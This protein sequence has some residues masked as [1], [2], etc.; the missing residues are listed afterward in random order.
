MA[1][2]ADEAGSQLPSE[3]PLLL[4]T[5]TIAIDLDGTL[6]SWTAFFIPLL[7]AIKKGDPKGEIVRV[8]CLTGCPQDS[9]DASDIAEKQTYL[10]EL[11]YD[12]LIDELHVVAKPVDENKADWC[13]ANN[14]RAL[15]D[16]NKKN[17][18]ALGS[19][20]LGLLAWQSRE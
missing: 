17:V 2:V 14:A 6:D 19:Q 9:V 20:C 1:T 4:V 10:S 7:T 11:G 16:N 12:G 18:K 13:E 15:I 5:T 3:D 8:V